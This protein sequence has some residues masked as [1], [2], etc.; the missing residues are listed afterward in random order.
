[1][2]NTSY[3]AGK[4]YATALFSLATENGLSS[5]DSQVEGL[6]NAIV[7]SNE[8]NAV[9][10]S[11]VIPASEKKAVL[12]NL[13]DGADA[14]F[15]NFISLVADKKRAGDLEEILEAYLQLVR[16]AQGVVTAYVESAAA[17]TAGQEKQVKE[18]VLAQQKGSKSVN[19]ETQVDADLL[20][21]FKIRIGSTEYDTSVRGR[22]NTLR[23]TL[24]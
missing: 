17:L 14:T 2:K 5:I 6:K 11:D 1:M 15:V 12:L 10:A 20:A 9:L 13:L 18:F 7:S 22:L 4:R 21:G 3:Q 19:L 8:L 24:N 16:D 23:T